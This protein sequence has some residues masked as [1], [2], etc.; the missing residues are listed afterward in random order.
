MNPPSAPVTPRAVDNLIQ[1]GNF[2]EGFVHWTVDDR[3]DPS[4]C[5]IANGGAH[6]KHGASIVQS[7]TVEAAAPYSVRMFTFSISGTATVQISQDRGDTLSFQV[8]P[9]AEKRRFQVVTAERTAQLTLKIIGLDA[10][11]MS[12]RTVTLVKDLPQGDELVLNGD[13]DFGSEHWLSGRGV[14]DGHTES[15]SFPAG[16]CRLSTTTDNVCQEILGMEVGATYEIKCAINAAPDSAGSVRIR[17]GASEQLL[18]TI[19]PQTQEYTYQWAATAAPVALYLHGGPA[20]FD[21]VSMKRIS[22]RQTWWRRWLEW[23]GGFAGRA[24]SRLSAKVRQ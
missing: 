11:P 5:T 10:D 17:D 21:F 16:S 23:L 9:Q 13:F 3:G 12:V 22:V 6:L 8:P 18:F 24:P 19:V 7:V 15:V 4:N 20:E 2:T 1:N 14:Q